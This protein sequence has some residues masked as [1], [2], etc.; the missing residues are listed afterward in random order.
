M[1]VSIDVANQIQRKKIIEEIEAPENKYRKE[2]SYRRFEIYRERQRKYIMQRLAGETSV[3]SV[4]DMRTITSIN[5]TRK[6]IHEMASIYKYAPNR[7][8]TDL[9]EQQTE[10][11]DSHYKYSKANINYKQSNRM[12]K[13]HE[14]CAIKIMPKHG[15]I[16][17]KVLQP[18]HY[19]VVP[20][21]YDPEKPEIYV[22]SSF[23]RQRIFTE[24]EF[25]NVKS[26]RFENRMYT[27]DGVNQKIGD[28]DDW[29]DQRRIYYWWTPQYN[30]ATDEAGNVLDDETKM[31]VSQPDLDAD[32]I[33]PIGRLPFVDVAI[34]KDDEFWVRSGSSIT[35]FNVD[36]GVQL[37][38]N[39]NINRL[40]G[41]S[42]AVITSVEQPKDILVGPHS[43][44]WLK[45]DPND[46]AAQR[47][48]FQFVTPSPDLSSSLQMSED[49]LRYFLASK[50]INLKAI[51]EGQM[52]AA[53]GL[54]KLL[55]MIEK[56]EASQDDIDL[57]KWVE[58]DAYEI[59]LKWHNVFRQTTD[60]FDPKVDGPSMPE[61]SEVMV[62]FSKPQMIQTK[63][64][65]LDH[66]IRQLDNG[67][68]TQI[69]AIEELREVD[70]EKAEEIYQKIKQ[71]ENQ[72]MSAMGGLAGVDQ[73]D[74]EI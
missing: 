39:V 66:I 38:D 55:Q 68:I 57:Y 34:E 72:D 17:M 31:P 44:L 62:Q 71:F 42:Q 41:F 50:S 30:F 49:L 53:S 64:E 37:S 5:L 4:R 45:A 47:P 65:K 74:E 19:D 60:G 2:E 69:E 56:F 48:S 6:M 15:F 61:E 46:D 36:F 29:R 21:M 54:E 35:E 23:D 18:H 11:M 43:C 12:F 9:S 33:N 73:S 52:T 40:Q 70:E 26:R 51:T 13:L 14:Q 24:N 10:V 59:M 8:Y 63:K 25:E 22:I 1:D 20:N 67:L 32:F 28:P 3:K 7:E 27:S 58:Q 16:N